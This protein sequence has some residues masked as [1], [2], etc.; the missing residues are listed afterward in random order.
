MRPAAAA[1]WRAESS[2][3]ACSPGG[4]AGASTT[5]AP[6]FERTFAW[7]HTYK[8]LLVRSD[9]RHDIHEAFLSLACSVVCFRRLQPSF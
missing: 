7:L 5:L 1:G 2:S 4:R 9:R 3:P 8:R 6:L